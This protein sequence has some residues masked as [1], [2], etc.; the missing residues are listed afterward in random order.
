M[1]WCER[2]LYGHDETVARFVAQLLG[3]TGFGAC[4][5]IGFLDRD[6]LLEAGAVYHN[7][8]PK[9]GVIEI[10]AA[11]LGH[12][13]G[14]RERLRTIFAYPFGFCRMVVARTSEHNPVPL[15]IWRALGASEYRI[16]ALRG[17]DEAE[18]VTTLTREQWQE[19]RYSGQ[20]I[21]SVS[22]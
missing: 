18:I 8:S 9:A 17:P 22:P 3:E 7:W 14:T 12:K 20:R 15:R 21:G 10:S 19:S 1:L 13:W 11:A 4:K 6:G 16:E 2:T 5:A